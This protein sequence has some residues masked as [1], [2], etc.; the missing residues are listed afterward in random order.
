[1]IVI[2]N[3]MRKK[4]K[5]I[6]FLKKLIGICKHSWTEWF[7]HPYSLGDFK[8]R[9]CTKCLKWE[10]IYKINDKLFDNVTVVGYI[11]FVQTNNN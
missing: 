11:V 9:Y 5:M 6:K 10:N 7:Y 8:S 1:M 4:I 2:L 3:I